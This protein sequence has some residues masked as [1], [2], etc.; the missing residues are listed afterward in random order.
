MDLMRFMVVAIL[1]GALATESA[2]QSTRAEQ[3]PICN[4]VLAVW[5]QSWNEAPQRSF[6]QSTNAPLECSWN[7]SA[8]DRSKA[9][10]SWPVVSNDGRS[11]HISAARDYRASGTMY[12]C[13]FT[14]DGDQWRLNTCDSTG[15]FDSF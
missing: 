6:D 3:L 2:A 15:V 14:R 10:F 12:I 4:M 1:L 13:N 8:N 7:S 5:S 11:A 9:L